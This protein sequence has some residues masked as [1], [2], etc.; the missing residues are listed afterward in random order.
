MQSHAAFFSSIFSPSSMCAICPCFSE[1]SLLSPKQRAHLRLHLT[2]TAVSTDCGKGLR[3]IVQGFAEPTLYDM[4]SIHP[5]SWRSKEEESE[6]ED[7][8]NAIGCI[9]A[10]SWAP[11]W[12][13]RINAA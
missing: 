11:K 12:K 2:N 5:K 13:S 9:L 7:R 1:L 3:G 8:R 10:P 4:W 6:P